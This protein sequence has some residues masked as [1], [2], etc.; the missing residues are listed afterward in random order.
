MPT[1]TVRQYRPSDGTY[2]VGTG[3]F[4]DLPAG[5]YGEDSILPSFQNGG[6][7]L[8]SDSLLGYDKGGEVPAP[9]GHFLAY[10]TPD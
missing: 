5:V 10:I 8:A 7:V 3:P 1:Y 9:P 4:P 6:V 2:E